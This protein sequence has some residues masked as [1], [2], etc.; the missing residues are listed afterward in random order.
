ME[1]SASGAGGHLWFFFA[2]ACNCASARQFGEFMLRETMKRNRH[3][4]F[5]SFDRMFPNQDRLPEGGF[6]NL[7]ALPLRASAY[8]N[9]NTAFINKYQQVIANPVEFLSIHPKI[10]LMRVAELLR[11][12]QEEDY[13]FDDPQPHLILSTEDVCAGEIRGTVS[14]M[15]NIDKT[16]SLIHI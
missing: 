9:G 10:S 12:F 3:L 11:A 2:E 4:K 13:F 15:L 14:G 1:R 16:L 5:S 8:R 7:I 6:G